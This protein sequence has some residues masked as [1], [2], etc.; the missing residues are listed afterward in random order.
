M[1]IAAIIKLLAAWS[2]AILYLS[3]ETVSILKMRLLIRVNPVSNNGDSHSFGPGHRRRGEYLHIVGG[4]P[5][6]LVAWGSAERSSAR[7]GA[8]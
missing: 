2:K 1:S 8:R 6:S 7:H 4:E 3:D 5:R